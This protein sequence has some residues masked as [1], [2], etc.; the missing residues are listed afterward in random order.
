MYG[1][2]SRTHLS[3]HHPSLV[4][5]RALRNANSF[6]SYSATGSV[7]GSG[8]G[9]DRPRFGSWGTG[10]AAGGPGTGIGR[11]AGRARYTPPA[12]TAAASPTATTGNNRRV[13]P[14]ATVSIAL[15]RELRSSARERPDRTRR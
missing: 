12:A 3:R 4:Y 13:R 11:S 2:V 7:L 6:A 5:S 9:L 1:P 10:A 15:S 14:D 8:S